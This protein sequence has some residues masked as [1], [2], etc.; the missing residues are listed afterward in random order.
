MPEEI[1]II[2]IN[3]VR[4]VGLKII[5]DG[6][7]EV[8]KYCTNG[9]EVINLIQLASGIAI[10]EDRQEI[11]LEDIKWVLENGQYNKGKR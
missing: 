9:R 11:T 1:K 2:A 8:S 4:K 7:E 10:N 6:V 3:C 5:Q